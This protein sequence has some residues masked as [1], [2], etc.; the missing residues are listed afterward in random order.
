MPALHLLFSHRLTPE[1]EQDAKKSL[2]V[3]RFIYLPKDLQRLFSNVPPDLEDLSKYVKPFVEYLLQN[4]KAGDYVLIQGDFGLSYKLT[5]VS[6]T[7]GFIP[8]YATTERAT[9]ERVENGKIIKISSFRHIR[10][11]RYQ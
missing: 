9:I 7:L 4:A 11:R 1:Q 8:I 2:K 6:L 3:D 5:Q 10:F